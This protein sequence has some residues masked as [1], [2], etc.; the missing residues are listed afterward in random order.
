MTNPSRGD[1]D[2]KLDGKTWA[3]RPSFGALRER[4]VVRRLERIEDKLD[5]QAQ[6]LAVSGDGLSLYPPNHYRWRQP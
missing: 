4:E 3:M 1:I 6:I 5:A 2:V